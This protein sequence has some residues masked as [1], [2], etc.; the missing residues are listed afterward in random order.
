MT[1]NAI[2]RQW[3]LARRPDGMVREDD[4]RFI[5][6]P[7]PA[8]AE[9]QVLVRTLWL[10][11]DPHQRLLMSQ[12]TIV[13]MMPLGEVVGAVGIG[14]VVESRRSDYRPGELVAG[15]FGWQDYVA[16]D[17]TEWVPMNKVPAGLQPNLALSLFGI[18][19]LTAYFGVLDVGQVKAGDIFV[20]SGAAGATGSIAGQIAKIKG[21]KV[22]GTTGGRAKCD[23]LTN[24]LGFDGVIDYRAENIGARLSALCPDGIDVFFDNVGGAVLNEALARVRLNGRVVLCGAISSYNDTTLLAGPSNYFQLVLKRGR[25][26]GFMVLDYAQR[27]PEATGTLATWHAEGKLKQKEDVAIGLENAPRTFARLFTGDKL[28]KQLLTIADQPLARVD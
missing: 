9:G 6:A 17:G 13:P 10:S 28:G 18:T 12:D 21:C 20:V 8:P 11:C 16:T 25:M 2:N 26:E 22:I 23:W 3:L 7:I 15:Y 1:H 19:G 27:F 4:F 24:E 5:E 14:Q